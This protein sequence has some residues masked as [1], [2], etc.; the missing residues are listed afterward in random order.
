MLSFWKPRK[1]TF[2]LVEFV[3]KINVKIKQENKE[4]RAVSYY[5]VHGGAQ[6][7]TGFGTVVGLGKPEESGP[8]QKQTLK[9]RKW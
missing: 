6:G 5:H 9:E 1:G 2:Q 8:R 3:N 7:A 4:N